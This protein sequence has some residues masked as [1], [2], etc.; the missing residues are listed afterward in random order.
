MAVSGTGGSG[1]AAGR[2]H[3]TKGGNNSS[4]VAAP[5][6]S[7]GGVVRSRRQRWT[8]NTA[9]GGGDV[10]IILG[11]NGYIWISK[12]ADGAAAASTTTENVSIT[13][14]EEMANSSIYSSQNDEIPRQTRREIARL[15]GCIRVL[16]EGGIRVD[17]DTVMRAY[18][19]SLEVD[20][21]MDDDDADHRREGRDYLGGEKAERIIEMVVQ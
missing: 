6:T 9:N 12:H 4:H 5:S 10:D 16:V 21:E 20:L 19:A 8:I 7:V 18:N 1:A 14:L 13:R 3:T 2:A 17:E 15:Q 11:V